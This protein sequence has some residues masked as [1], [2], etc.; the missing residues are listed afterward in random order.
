MLLFVAAV[1]FALVASF[2]CSLSEATL[3]SVSPGKIEALVSQG[4]RAGHILRRFKQKPDAPIAA[5]LVLNTVATTAC[6]AVAGA[7]FHDAFGGV[8]DV[9]FVLVF[10]AT[11]L[12]FTEITPKTVGVVHSSQMAIPVAHI[13]EVMVIVL[14]PVLRLTRLV[15]RLVGSGSA[16][17]EHSLEEIRLLATAGHAHG[18]FGSLTAEIIANATRLRDQRVRDVMVPR[19]RVA[20]VAGNRTPDE[21]LDLMRRT[22]HSRFPYTPTGELDGAQGVVLTKELLFHLRTQAEPDWDQLLVP[23]L[24]VPETAKLNYVL[25]GFQKEKRHM[26]LV[27]DEYGAVQGIV[28]LEDVLEEI[29]G[30]IEDEL[31]D[32]ENPFVTRP[33]GSV[34]CRGQAEARKVFMR[35]GLRDVDTQSQTVSG[36]LTERLGDVPWA[37]AEVDYRGYRFTVTKANNRRAERVRITPI[38]APT[39]GDG[40]DAD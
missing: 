35:L 9:W 19:N 12:L 15:S 40:A 25:R 17:H 34:L 18:A 26:A 39:A 23:L 16:L 24:I 1:T 4:R 2:V 27:V 21:I 14:Q 31:D 32:D 22:G 30:E 8:A 38:P 13:V 37:S 3:L 7:S 5:I 36:F 11:I 33:D 6:A 29:V 20:C 10:T 28:T